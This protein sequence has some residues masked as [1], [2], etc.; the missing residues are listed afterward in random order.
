MVMSSLTLDD[1]REAYRKLEALGPMPELR[2]TPHICP[3]NAYKFTYEGREIIFMNDEE[4]EL[5]DEDCVRCSN[6]NCKR[7]INLYDEPVFPIQKVTTT[8]Y[9]CGRC[10]LERNKN[11]TQRD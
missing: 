7:E 3:G 9:L 6:P 4:L 5:L 11:D 1:I 2:G 8:V 10:V